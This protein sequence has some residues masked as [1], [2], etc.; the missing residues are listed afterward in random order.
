M[1][2]LYVYYIIYYVSLLD[3][4]YIPYDSVLSTQYMAYLYATVVNFNHPNNL[5]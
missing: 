1:A 3:I 2:Y 4:Y 5:N